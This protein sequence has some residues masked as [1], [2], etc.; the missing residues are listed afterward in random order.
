MKITK[1]VVEEITEDSI[2]ILAGEEEREIVVP[3]DELALPGELKEGDWLE[4]EMA[5]DKIIII[6]K[7]EEETR[8]VKKRI[9]EK[10][11]L[12]RKRSADNRDD[13]QG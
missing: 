10:M 8:H 9:L 1:A 2:T 5:D 12:L 13:K 4:I 6:R 3:R 7:N 11:D